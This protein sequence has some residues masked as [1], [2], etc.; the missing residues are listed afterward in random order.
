HDGV[1]RM[2]FPGASGRTHIE[3][4]ERLPGVANFLVGPEEEWR[5]GLPLYSG[6]IYRELY[7]GIDMIYGSDGRKLKSQF[8]VAPGFDPSRILVQYVGAGK[9]RVDS[10]GSLVIPVS[11]REVREQAPVVYQERH[12]ERLPV[13]G[14]FALF[15]DAVGF[16]IGDYDR[17]A[18]LVIDPTVSYS[19]LLGGSNS[20]AAMSL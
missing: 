8:V 5:V 12:G 17:T 19:T 20:D 10:D 18:P 1:V 15:G 13:E 11:T 3:P 7:A 2:Q 14:R 6:V 16:I 4:L 9:L